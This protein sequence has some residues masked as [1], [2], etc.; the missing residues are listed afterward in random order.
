MHG[1]GV[2]SLGGAGSDDKGLGLCPGR[3]RVPSCWNRVVTAPC[4][5][6]PRALVL[7][8]L[9]GKDFYRLV[10]LFTHMN[11]MKNK[12]IINNKIHQK[13]AEQV[14]SILLT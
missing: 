9:Y 1:D 12:K 8:F 2:G 7:L 11:H 4:R 6:H 3:W 10:F 14:H 13:Y 5:Q